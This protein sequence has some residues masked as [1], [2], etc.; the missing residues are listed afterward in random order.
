MFSLAC[1]QAGALTK[2]MVEKM[3][4]RPIIF[5]MANPVPE[6]WPAEAKEVRPDAVIATWTVG[7]SKSGE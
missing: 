5:A 6:I 7:F 2:G 1:H 4:P 3:A